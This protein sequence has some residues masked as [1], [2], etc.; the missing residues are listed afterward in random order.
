MQITTARETAEA[1][2][3][4]VRKELQTARVLLERVSL[5]S[6]TYKSPPHNLIF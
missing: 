2:A 6:S 5:V 1:G 3:E 4:L